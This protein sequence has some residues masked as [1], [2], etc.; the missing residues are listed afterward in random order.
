[1]SARP[2]PKRIAHQKTEKARE[3]ATA[4]A[5]RGEHAEISPPAIP[6]TTCKTA[7]ALPIFALHIPIKAAPSPMLLVIVVATAVAPAGGSAKS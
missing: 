5:Q 6:A 3:T 7:H 1:M 4:Q 2:T